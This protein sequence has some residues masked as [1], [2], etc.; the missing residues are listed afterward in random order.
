MK[1]DLHCHTQKI[2]DGDPEERKISIAE[3]HNKMLQNDVKIV[4]IT[5]H[6]CFDIEEYKNIKKI[7]KSNYMI[8][9]GI[10]LDINE[11]GDSG[12]VI[13][14]CN[15]RNV[16][17][18]NNF[19]TKIIGTT[20][21]NDFSITLEEL[22]KKSKNID[23]IYAFHYH[24]RPDISVENIQKFETMLKEKHRVFYEPTNYRKLG[25][26]TSEGYRTILGSDVRNWND[27][28]NI[29]LPTLKLN[30]DSFENFLLLAKKDKA[31]VNTMLSKKNKIN[32]ECKIDARKTEIIPIYDDVN[33]IFGAKGTGK[34]VMLKKIESAFITMGKSVSCYNADSISEKF[35]NKLKI[36]EKERNDNKLEIQECKENIKFIKEWTD[37]TPTAI[38]DYID[39]IE[40]EDI[41]SNKKKLKII[42]ISDFCLENEEYENVSNAYKSMCDFKERFNKDISIFLNKKIV[43]KFNEILDFIINKLLIIKEQKWLEKYTDKFYKFSIEKIRN[44]VDMKTGTKSKP[45]NTGFLEYSINKLKLY[46]N[47]IEIKNNFQDK[48]LCIQAW[49]G[50]LEEKKD[51]YIETRYK[52]LSRESVT[53]EFECNITLL[54]DFKNIIEKIENNLFEIELYDNISEL[55]DERF[56]NIDT[57][58][59]FIGVSKYCVIKKK[60]EKFEKYEPS[61]GEETMLILHERLN[62][63][64]DIYILDE[65]EKSLGNS[66]INDVIVPIINNLA[67]M[68]KTLI[69]ATHNANIAVRTLPYTSVYKEYNGEY[70]TFIGNP[71]IDQLINIE[72]KDDIRNWKEMSLKCLEGGEQAFD[73]RGEIYGRI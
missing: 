21:P 23:L 58:K 37:F 25:I 57:L 14:I 69:I 43:D 52:I 1:I 29:K 53:A 66:Y 63:N 55:R 39:F 24:K 60:D 27:Y 56:Y 62:E 19:I 59:K 22:Y 18:F 67:N 8:W 38:K 61:K 64:K 54:R 34:S 20:N 3:F 40:S 12:H 16:I 36:T 46:K 65:P 73:E 32:V 26:L 41:N 11:N 48:C 30:I 51:V 9:P 7:S 70:L 15:P 2:K 5:N 72:D 6:N 49:L 33:I 68:K 35:N 50:K 71:F 28:K 10:E 31:I 45:S 47:I 42:E 4:S 17:K 44:L 13:L